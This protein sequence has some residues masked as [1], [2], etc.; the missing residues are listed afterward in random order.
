GLGWGT[1]IYEFVRAANYHDYNNLDIYP[2]M[3]GLGLQNVAF[4]SNH[5]C[6]KLSEKYNANVHYLY[7]PAIA[8][9]EAVKNVF[10][11]TSL[12]KEVHKQGLKVDLAI[13]GIA[14]PVISETYKH[15]ENVS[16]EE[17]Q[18]LK[19]KEVVGDIYASFFDINGEEVITSLSRKMAGVKLSEL[20]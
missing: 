6:F 18:E 17:L 15:L 5:L 3:G 7:A 2:L 1:T 8:E 9:N 10:I 16:D 20:H 19:E 14:N 11:D 12:Y 4:H 13:S